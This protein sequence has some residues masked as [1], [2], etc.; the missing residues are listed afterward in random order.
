LFVLAPIS[1]DDVNNKPSGTAKREM[2]IAIFCGLFVVAFVLIS[3]IGVI[4]G[5]VMLWR[6]FT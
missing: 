3:V 4:V 2:S 5:L 1:G 6:T